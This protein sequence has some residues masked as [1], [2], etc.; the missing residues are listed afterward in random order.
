MRRSAVSS[1]LA[2][3]VRKRLLLGLGTELLLKAAFLNAGYAINLRAGKPPFPVKFGDIA[4]AEL[5]PKTASLDDCIKNL[6]KVLPRQ[7]LQ[8]AKEGLMIARAFRNK[9]AHSV[10]A[11]HRFDPETYRIIEAA[12]KAVYR[13]AFGEALSVTIAMTKDDRAAWRIRSNA[14]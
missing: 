12:L 3:N 8:E 11:A 4:D 5:K 6:A 13:G 14:T 10:L 2:R 9:E 1:L 7:D